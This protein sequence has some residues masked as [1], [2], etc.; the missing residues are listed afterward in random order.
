ML[1]FKLVLASLAVSAM[2]IPAPE[3]NLV[4]EV[5]SIEEGIA[6]LPT[7]W[8][9]S[10]WLPHSYSHSHSHH[11][12]HSPSTAVSTLATPSPTET[13]TRA[14]STSES[15]S[16]S[17][18]PTQAP[19]S[20]ENPVSSSSSSAPSASPSVSSS[21]AA[22]SPTGS[23]SPSAAAYLDPHNAL[24]AQ[25]SVPPLNW[26]TE[27][28]AAAQTWASKCEWA[29]SNG[30]VG[31][32]GE[33]IAAGTGDFNATSAVAAWAAEEPLYNSSAPLV[34]HYTQMVWKSSTQLGCAVAS[35]PGLISSDVA[36]LHVCEYNPAGNVIGE[37]PQNVF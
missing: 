1:N 8:W 31:A 15:K 20:T 9:H 10:A 7:V 26:S 23:L 4:Q 17:V 37:F 5:S 27:L 19:T 33:N 36:Q 2:A 24:R 3:F 35:C 30:T 22:A 16:A 13:E 18:T 6:A 14:A 11:G 29:H 34:S 12:S 25:H 28:A 21:A 32:Y